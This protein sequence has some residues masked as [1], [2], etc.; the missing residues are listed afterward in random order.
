[1]SEES[2]VK[3]G[4]YARE[5]RDTVIK[6]GLTG[7]AATMLAVTVFSPAGFG[8]IVGT[9]LASGLGMGPESAPA[10]DIYANLPA[11][12]APL[13]VVEIAS[14]EDRLAQTSVE[15]DS[16]RAATEPTI[17]HVRAIALTEGIVTFSPAPVMA[18]RAPM[19]EAP[20]PAVFQTPVVAPAPVL[21]A[22][23]TEIESV[24]LSAPHAL[25]PAPTISDEADEPMI[26]IV[27]YSYSGI[28]FEPYVGTHLELA[29][30]M[31]MSEPL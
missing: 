10:E 6:S 22:Q 3:F 17:K 24:D 28:E 20:L 14:I 23:A 11:Y 29:D 4:G 13:S 30:L 1:M 9:S 25:Q 26:T 7:V 21:V 18:A 8:G 27:D 2:T 16:V 15:H 19:P 31:F 12:P 5:V